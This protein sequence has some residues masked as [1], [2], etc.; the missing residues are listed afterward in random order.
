M[1]NEN[2]L[3]FGKAKDAK[4]RTIASTLKRLFPNHHPHELRYTFITR[5]KECGVNPEVVM[6]WDGHSFDKDVKTTEVDL[7]YTNYSEEYLKKSTV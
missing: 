2:Y 4:Q 1:L 6:L 5:C 3:D 7:G